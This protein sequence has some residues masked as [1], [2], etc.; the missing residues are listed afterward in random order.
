M[1]SVCCVA[2]IFA[3]IAAAAAV[4]ELGHLVVLRSLGG[5]VTKI[6]F[7]AMG[8]KIDYRGNGMSYGAEAAAAAGG[9]IAGAA[10][11]GIACL[12][13][14]AFRWEGWYMLGGASAVLTVFNML[15]SSAMDG[16]RII[17]MLMRRTA[18]LEKAEL[19]CTFLDGITS[20]TV[21]ALG[22]AIW[23]YT[24][25]NPTLFA[26]GVWLFANFVLSKLS[27]RYKITQ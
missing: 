12:L 7:Q 14:R 21:M 4:H 22:L 11:T 5:R 1:L 9:L 3:Y 13:G 2:D 8:L 23:M 10:L 26:A 25:T 17:S 15:P 27:I 18:E 16:G 6:S 20:L 24:G 19:I